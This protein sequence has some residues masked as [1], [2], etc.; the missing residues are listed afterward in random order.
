MSHQLSMSVQNNSSYTL[1]T[2]SVSHSWDGNNENLNGQNLANGGASSPSVQITSGYTQYDW[3]TVQLTFD[4]LGVRQTNF[5]CNSSYSQNGCVVSVHDTS[6][7][8]QYFSNGTYETGCN[9]KSYSGAFEDEA[10]Q[11]DPLKKAS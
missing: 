11:T 2:Y 4:V 5:Y 1:K 10:N 9:G 6:L 7:D 3:F 8:L